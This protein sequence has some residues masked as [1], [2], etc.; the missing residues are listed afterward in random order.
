MND[1]AE[2]SQAKP[3]GQCG[4]EQAELR[5]EQIRSEWNGVKARGEK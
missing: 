3:I 5:N 4:S 1:R 2:L